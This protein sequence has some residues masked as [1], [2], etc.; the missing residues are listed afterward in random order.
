[1]TI[2][3][4]FQ[5]TQNHHCLESSVKS[6][7]KLRMP[8]FCAK[9]ACVIFVT[10]SACETTRKIN[11]ALVVLGLVMR[12]IMVNKIPPEWISGKTPG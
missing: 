7:M 3:T 1:M 11:H 5:Y 4:N 6:L 8:G 2:R 12:H 10:D 9:T